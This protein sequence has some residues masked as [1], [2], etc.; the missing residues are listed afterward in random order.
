MH[1]I[2]RGRT[3]LVTLFALCVMSCGSQ[4]GT[5]RLSDSS[6]LGTLA[7]ATN[8]V[9]SPPSGCTGPAD[10]G[11]APV[12]SVYPLRTDAPESDAPVDPNVTRPKFSSTQAAVDDVVRRLNFV[13]IKVARVGGPPSSDAFGPWLYVLATVPAD[14]G[15]VPVRPQWETVTI[16]GAAAELAATGKELGD[17]IEGF[18]LDLQTADCQIVSATSTR[19]GPRA[20]GQ[21]FAATGDAADTEFATG[22]LTKFGVT[23]VKVET[24]RGVSQILTVTASIPNADAMQGNLTAMFEALKGAPL[25]FESVYLQLQTTAGEDLAVFGNSPRL[26]SGLIWFQP[27]LE[28]VLGLTHG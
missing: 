26:A 7:S 13:D 14:T 15:A 25:R 19:I 2:S 18:V 10:F 9:V 24:L 8:S 21:V 3:A 22:V 17:A 12:P 6:T 1:T 20:S 23:P 5:S 4:T 16:M 28:D 27:G 11:S